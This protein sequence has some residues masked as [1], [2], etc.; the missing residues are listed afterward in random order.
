MAMA[1]KPLQLGADV[2]KREVVICR[3]DS[4]LLV[5][6]ANERPV[7]RAWLKR[8]PG[9]ARLAV[10]ATNT[11]HLALI[12]EAHRLG[13]VVYV[14]D[15]Y[16]LNRYR[17]SVGT[18]AKTDAGDA[19]LLLRYL[20]REGLDL[21]PWEPPA[22][23]YTVL[24]RLLRR[25]ATLVQVTTTLEQSL[26][27]LPELKRHTQHLLR[28]LKQLET[29]IRQ[30]LREAVRQQ[31]WLSQVQRCQA[32]EGVGPITA[33][34]LTMSYQR[35][36]FKSA[37]AFIA[38]LGLDVRVR[39]SGTHRGRRK[40]TKQG[41]PEL[42]RLLYLA[43]MTACRSATWQGFYQRYLARGLAKI[44]ALVILAR[45]LARVAFALLRNQTDYQPKTT[46]A[47]CAAT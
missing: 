19:R 13:H 10:E 24:Q 37:D 29:V 42:R 26:R 11:Y 20:D 23:G 40:L 17:E 14:V 12:E 27:D 32:I 41:D 36:A 25:R 47:A 5:S 44:Q 30:R 4:E 3:S 1:V 35:G 21:R 18:R 28:E 33:T 22:P 9:P 7:L 6:L 2:S 34:A 38:F 45:K 43:A 46:T 15:G 39:D 16:R 31:G 8:L